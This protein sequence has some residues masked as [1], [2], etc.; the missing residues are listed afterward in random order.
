MITTAMR[1]TTDAGMPRPN[2]ARIYVT[3]ARHEFVKL[4]RI[5]IFAVST[6]ALPVMFYVLFGLAFGGDEAGGVGRT[7]YM[8]SAFGVLAGIA[9]LVMIGQRVAPPQQAANSAESRQACKVE[10]PDELKSAAAHWCAIGLFSHVTLSTKDQ[11]VIAV[12]QLSQ[13]GG[14]A[15]QMQSTGLIGEFRTN[16]D[17]LAA[18]GG[19][20][21]GLV[22]RW[23]R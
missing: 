4:I 2:P 5:P 3:E 17:R 16:T 8:L 23:R 11:D 22:A 20:R 1:T 10:S 14:Q 21:C 15:W 19:F 7:T 12:L 18:V 6:I 9:A 13:N